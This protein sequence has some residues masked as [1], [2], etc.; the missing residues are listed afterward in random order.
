MERGLLERYQPLPDPDPEV[1]GRVR[2][3][4]QES[5]AGTVHADDYTSAAWKE[6]CLGQKLD[7]PILESFGGLV[8]LTLVDQSKE[9]NKRCYRFRVQCERNTLLQQVVLDDRNRVVLSR[10]EDAR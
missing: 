4:I 1:A 10:L 6:A 3:I 2:R 9:G 7:R 8:K 5:L